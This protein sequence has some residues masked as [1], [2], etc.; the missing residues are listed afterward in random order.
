MRNIILSACCCCVVVFWPVSGLCKTNRTFQ[1]FCG[2]EWSKKAVLRNIPFW[3]GSPTLENGLAM[4]N[5]ETASIKL[6]WQ[7]IN[8]VI[9]LEAP[10]L[11]FLLIIWIPDN[12]GGTHYSEVV[13]NCE[14]DWFYYFE[15]NLTDLKVSLDLHFKKKSAGGWVINRFKRW[16]I[17][18][19]LGLS[20]TGEGGR[21]AVFGD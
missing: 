3:L 12:H 21:Y 16:L 4:N 6:S 14:A 10:S 1:S 11:S 17:L 7:K 5:S 2:Q 8:S 19:L 13:C 15:D 9:H 18:I 20:T